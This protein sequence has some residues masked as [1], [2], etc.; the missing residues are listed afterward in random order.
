LLPDGREELKAERPQGSWRD[1]RGVLKG[2]TNGRRLSIEEI[3]EAVTEAGARRRGRG[4]PQATAAGGASRPRRRRARWHLASRSGTP[5][6]LPGGVTILAVATILV[7]HAPDWRWLMGRM[8][9]P[10]IP[11]AAVSAARAD[12]LAGG[13]GAPEGGFDGVRRVGRVKPANTAGPRCADCGPHG[14]AR[15]GKSSGASLRRRV[16]PA[17]RVRWGTRWQNPGLRLKRSRS[18]APSS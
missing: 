2:K 7:P 5:A 16:A 13:A 6:E 15:A 17:L 11:P 1:L 3:N 9:S 14:G 18:S 8:D 4:G 10:G 12:G